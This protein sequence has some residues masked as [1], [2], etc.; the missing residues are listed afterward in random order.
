MAS[1]NLKTMR[2]M[3]PLSPSDD[4]ENIAGSPMSSNGFPQADD[5]DDDENK[6]VRMLLVKKVLVIFKALLYLITTENLIIMMKLFNKFMPNHCFTNQIVFCSAGNIKIKYVT[7]KCKTVICSKKETVQSTHNLK[8]SLWYGGVNIIP[9][10]S[11]NCPRHGCV[12]I[13]YE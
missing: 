6:P 2:I 11:I 5:D 8:R 10:C 3:S 7:G 12:H 13:A 1:A 4:I 9:I